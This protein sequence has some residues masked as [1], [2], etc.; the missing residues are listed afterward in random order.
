VSSRRAAPVKV[1]LADFVMLSSLLLL[2]V[3]VMLEN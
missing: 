2:V 3:E 1:L